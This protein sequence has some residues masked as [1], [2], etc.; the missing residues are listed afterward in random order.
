MNATLGKLLY[1][2]VFCLA[3]PLMLAWWTMR[4]GPKLSALPVLHSTP[5]GAAIAAG[6]VALML[7]AMWDLWRR[8]GGLPM[9]AF[10]PP[11]LVATGAYRWLPHPI[12]AGFGLLVPGVMIAL[13]SRAGLWMV[14]PVVWLAMVA[15]VVGFE[16]I[17]LG[18]RFGAARPRAWLSRPPNDPAAPAVGQR[19]ATLVLAFVPWL[20]AYEACALLGA[21]G[22]S[23]DTMLPFERAWPV[24]EWTAVLYL[25]AYAWT[26]FAPFTARTQSA[27][28]DFTGTA[29]W[30]TGFIV[31]CF[32]VFPFISA[33]RPVDA[34]SGFG[35][36]LLLD[37]SLDTPACAF[38]SFHVFWA[39]AAA[40]LWAVRL[41]AGTSR[42]VALLIAA[43]C[44]TT[45]LHSLVDVAAGWV[46]Y[47]G[48]THRRT[49]WEL[50][51]RGS[52]RIA[53]AWRRAVL[54]SMGT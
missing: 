25:G 45:G 18:R 48:A 39:F 37:R 6:G 8:G 15:L 36:L 40:D 10:P 26:A 27:V 29:L 16:R 2:A 4:L 46:V 54:T 9:N 38:P 42:I 31:W 17:D 5:I 35:R 32:L 53:N 30:G 52:E 44:L 49:I 13:G 28:R 34:G 47:L 51:R 14:T 50:L 23:I 24:W 3:L 1:A 43:S 33:S 22:I 20:L 11:R 7:H 41:G 21:P 12:Y 19:I